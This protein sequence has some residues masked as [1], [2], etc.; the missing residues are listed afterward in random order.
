MLSGL[1][2]SPFFLA[3][4]RRVL[5]DLWTVV[6]NMPGNRYGHAAAPLSDGRVLACG[7]YD[8]SYHNTT[9]IYG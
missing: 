2:M 7:G 4:A 5:R 8:G 1:T 6:A 3:G 9:W